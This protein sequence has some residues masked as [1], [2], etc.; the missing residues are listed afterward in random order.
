MVNVQAAGFGRALVGKGRLELPRRLWA[1]DP[2]SC[3]SAIPPLPHRRSL[4]Y[5]TRLVART[6]A[7]ARSRTCRAPSSGCG[8]SF[9]GRRIY[10][11]NSSVWRIARERLRRR[12]SGRLGVQEYKRQQH[13][14]RMHQRKAACQKVHESRSYPCDRPTRGAHPLATGH[15]GSQP[16]GSDEQANED[17]LSC[18]TEYLSFYW[19][20][21]NTLSS[22]FALHRSLSE[23]Q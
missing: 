2:K 1:H 8:A 9:R 14:E 22:L 20:F 12:D 5:R 13:H 16:H 21:F 15:Q 3:A 7:A 6:P 17:G 23:H 19:R 11:D 10:G 18:R 4:S